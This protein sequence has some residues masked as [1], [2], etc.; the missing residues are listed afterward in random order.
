[1]I[2]DGEAEPFCLGRLSCMC[3]RDSIV[4]NFNLILRFVVSNRHFLKLS[5]LWVWLTLA[6]I[7]QVYDL[8]VPL[9]N[10]SLTVRERQDNS[11]YVEGLLHVP[12]SRL[13]SQGIRTIGWNA[14]EIILQND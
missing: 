3:C 8:M 9:S 6:V 14:F 10:R 1:M 11:V 2:D 5:R 13:E 7:V 4:V 12:I